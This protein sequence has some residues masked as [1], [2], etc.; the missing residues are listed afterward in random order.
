MITPLDSEQSNLV[1]TKLLIFAKFC[2]GQWVT[3]IYFLSIKRNNVKP[4]TK[5]EV[6]IIIKE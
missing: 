4:F 3:T 2:H 1:Y 6:L 5:K